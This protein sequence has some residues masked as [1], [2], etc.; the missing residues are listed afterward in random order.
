[1]KSI[2]LFSL[3]TFITG[4]PLLALAIIIILYIFIDR[5]FI[6]ILPDFTA[7]WRRRARIAELERTVRANPH[8]GDAL[9]ELGTLYYHRKQYH[10]ALEV[11][12]QA[13]EKMKAWPD[14][15]FY[16][17]AACYETGNTGRGL[18]EIGDAVRISPRIMHGF[19]YIYMIRA[20]LEGK[21]DGDGG[22]EDLECELLR[23][24]SVQ[25]FFEAGVLFHRF[26]R[27][28]RSDRFFRE[29]LDNYRLS[30]PTFRRTYRRMA[31]MS[32]LYLR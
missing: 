24:G 5:S 22:T 6:G 29:V 10:R 2:F 14:V 13:Y 1:M 9:L 16:L 8:N 7:P 15:H 31:I 12:E 11:L 25:A 17:G 18:A 4:N 21:A 23:Y 27:K 30:S 32:K 26:G 3:I 19:P 28:E 20:V